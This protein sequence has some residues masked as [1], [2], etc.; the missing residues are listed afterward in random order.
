MKEEIMFQHI[1]FPTDISD[2]SNEA[3]YHAVDL[4]R[5]Y[6]GKITLL[7]IH[8]EFMDME[9][10]QNLRVSAANYQ[11]FMREKAVECRTVMEKLAASGGLKKG[12]YEIM[13]RQG[14][15]R[16]EI[17]NIAKSI[18][19]DIIVMRS[20]GRTSLAEQIMG[21]V[22]EHVIRVSEIPVLVIKKTK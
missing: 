7:N 10:M 9:E 8:E 15:P 14:N 11:D 12:E 19:A 16:K 20:I 2:K 17:L 3:F 18:K 22:A 13:I 1:L 5:K 4:R 6:G 21:S